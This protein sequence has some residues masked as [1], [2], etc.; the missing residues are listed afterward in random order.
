MRI[1]GP[2]VLL[3]LWG[4]ACS[5]QSTEPTP[6]LKRV[7]NS[8]NYYEG[9]DQEPPPGVPAEYQ[10]P[11]FI[12]SIEPTAGYRDGYAWA[13][14]IVRYTG[15]SVQIRVKVSTNVDEQESEQTGYQ[16]LPAYNSI[17]HDVNSLMGACGGNIRADVFAKVW[18]EA[19][20][21]KFA[22]WGTKSD[23]RSAYN[24]CPRTIR[25]E[26]NTVSTGSG[27]SD[28]V[29]YRLDIDYYYY[30]PDTGEIEYRYTDTRSWCEPASGYEM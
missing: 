3:L 15:T 25:R 6:D 16:L 19:P 22:P 27:S 30:Y 17:L 1:S 14:G 13:Q 20:L 5:E 21:L 7:N 8:A 12:H 24:T 23:Q 26:S 10:F 18:N 9:D 28:R 2:A 29:C 4:V 11:T